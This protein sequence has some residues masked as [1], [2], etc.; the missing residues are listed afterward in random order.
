MRSRHDAI[1]EVDYKI[2]EKTNLEFVVH[3][4][5]IGYF[6]PVVFSHDGFWFDKN[7]YAKVVIGFMNLLTFLYS[8]GITIDTEV[9]VPTD[10]EAELYKGILREDNHTDIIKCYILTEIDFT[11]FNLAGAII[12]DN[13][14]EEDYSLIKL[15]L[16]LRT[17][18]ALNKKAIEN[19]LRKKLT[20]AE[21]HTIR[22]QLES[23][24][25]KEMVKR[26]DNSYEMR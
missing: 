8:C 23:I 2:G 20:D 13:C 26:K 3:L 18:A 22:R 7:R 12:P 6:N 16:Q 1:Q 10:I 17:G 14:D 4:L 5:D 11:S 9:H 21:M 15:Y 19:T 24:T 25:G